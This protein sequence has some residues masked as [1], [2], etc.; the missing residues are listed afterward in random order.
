[1][2]IFSQLFLTPIST[3]GM[4][5]TL[6]LDRFTFYKVETLSATKSVMMH[7]HHFPVSTV[8]PFDFAPNQMSRLVSSWVQIST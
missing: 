3:G 8:F 5:F 2:M 1:M 6:D 7:F 4:V